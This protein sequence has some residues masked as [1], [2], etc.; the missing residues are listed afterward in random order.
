VRAGLA[1]R[2]LLELI[3]PSRCPACDQPRR[4]GQTLLCAD[5]ALELRPLA[6]LGRIR[7]GVAYEGCGLRLLRRFKFEGRSDALEVLL[8]ALL[9]RLEGLDVD[10][11]VPVP[12]HPQRVRETGLDPVFALGRRLARERGWPLWDAVLVRGRATPTQTGRTLEARRRNVAGAFRVAGA[13][14]RGACVLLVDDV[15]T[16]GATLDE[17]A[18]CLRAAGVRR[19]CRAALAGTP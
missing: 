4:P 7:T 2:A 1:R 16:T 13:R 6:R 8:P 11:V 17:A 3:S 10:G 19:V 9:A 12:R 18:R 15:A 14:A 5:C